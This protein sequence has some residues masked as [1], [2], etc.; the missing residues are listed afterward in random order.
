MNTTTWKY[1]KLIIRMGLMLLACFQAQALV[2]ELQRQAL[3]D[4]YNETGGLDDWSNDTNWLTDDP[5]ANEWYGVVCDPND[6]ITG[7]NLAENNLNGQIPTSLTQLIFLE[8]LNLSNS[9]VQLPPELGQISSLKHLNL[10]NSSFDLFPNNEFPLWVLS[11]SNLEILNL[12][13]N[14]IIDEIPVDINLLAEL[15]ELD[16]SENTLTGE[17]PLGLTELINLEVLDLFDY[18]GNEFSGSFPAQMTLLVNLEVLRISVS[19]Y[20][21]FSGDI[22]ADIGLLSQLRELTLA[23]PFSGNLPPSIADLDQL[24]ALWI[25]SNGMETIEF[26]QYVLQMTNL[27]YLKLSIGMNGSIPLNI[28]V[29]SQLEGLDLSHNNL[30]GPI[31]TG[32]GQLSG[33]RSLVLSSNDLTGTIP[34]ELSAI[35]GLRSLVLGFNRLNGNYPSWVHVSQSLDFLNITGNAINGLIRDAYFQQ[36][37]IRL[38]ASYNALELESDMLLSDFNMYCF[39]DWEAT[40]TL[41]PSNLSLDQLDD[42]HALLSWNPI[43][44]DHVEGGYEVWL[45]SA[46]QASFQKHQTIKSKSAESAVISGLQPGQSYELYMKSFSSFYRR[47]GSSLGSKV[48]SENS[49]T[50]DFQQTFHSPAQSSLG[51]KLDAVN[52]ETSGR[53]ATY[54]VVVSNT[55]PDTVSSALFSVFGHNPPDNGYA[56]TVFWVSCQDSSVNAV[57]PEINSFDY[58]FNLEL[59][60]PAESW[61]KF[62][63]GLYRNISFN[64]DQTLLPHHV[65]QILPPGGMTD[66]DFSDNQMSIRL[67]DF[68]F[69]Q[70]FED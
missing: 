63:I 10:R 18:G 61:F 69:E 55:G 65:I 45:K 36:R 8:E 17:I 21:D 23:G 40:Q 52:V 54:D 53:L 67:Y 57:C 3:V 46:D 20:A 28:S 58:N 33:L 4:L 42:T 60:M 56:Y 6:N 30:S 44:Y 68:I 1:P 49:E 32:I 11:L 37:I 12:S 22:P 31:P 64:N 51:A 9:Y 70:N 19:S 24:T 48:Y 15:K 2:P 7:L 38:F 34:S 26:P 39:C 25:E 29:L 47:D 13:E 66:N 43:S 59:N 14:F 50:E 62:R 27:L 35:T 16:L 5:C 41:A